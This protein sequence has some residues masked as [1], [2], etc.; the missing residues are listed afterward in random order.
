MKQINKQDNKQ[1]DNPISDLILNCNRVQIIVDA[2]ELLQDGYPLDSRTITKL[3][4]I[5]VNYIEFT[6]RFEIKE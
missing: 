3:G 6:K 2:I 1:R 5:G 4:S